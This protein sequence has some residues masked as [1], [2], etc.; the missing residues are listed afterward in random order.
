M[1]TISKSTIVTIMCMVASFCCC[2]TG[3][4]KEETNKTAKSVTVTTIAGAAGDAGALDGSATQARFNHP[5]GLV[6]DKGGNLFIADRDNDCIR[7]I[8]PAGTVSIFAGSPGIAS[9]VDGN[10]T[11]AH[12]RDPSDVVLDKAGNLYVLDLNNNCIRKITPDGTVSR[13]A[14]QRPDKEGVED[15]YR[16]EILLRGPSGVVIDSKDNMYVLLA[17][18]IV[19]I[20]PDGNAT[21][22]LTTRAGEGM[23]K[24]GRLA[25]AGF[26]SLQSMT[27]DN[28]DNIYVSQRATRSIRKISADGIVSTFFAIPW[29][30]KDTATVGRLPISSIDVMVADHSG[31]L[32][33]S[34]NNH[35]AIYKISADGRCVPYA[36]KTV[37]YSNTPTFS[38][39]S[40]DG[41]GDAATFNSIGGMTIDQKGSLF[42]TDYSNHT[43]R[44]ISAP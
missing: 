40:I 25:E 9:L 8:T 6:F 19:K 3:T 12:F 24:D 4:S 32:Y 1:Q 44:K 34:D 22:F 29:K 5:K 20:T 17:L 27:I 42:V 43:I 28:K 11:A 15:G 7:K 31:N 16:T 37:V 14:G 30:G 21:T 18:K 26:T 39:T 41:K 23:E 38:K 36:G 10:G 35:H 13:Y 2:K 33:V